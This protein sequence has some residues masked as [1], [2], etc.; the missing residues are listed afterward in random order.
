MNVLT[1]YIVREVLKGSFISLVLLLTLFNLFTFTDELKS[2]G[3]GSYGLQEIFKYLALTSPRVLYELIPSSALLG[4][5]FVLGAMGNNRELIAMRASGISVLGIVRSVMLAG[6]ILAIFAVAVGE[7]FA[8]TAERNARIL[9]MGALN[10]DFIAQSRYGLWLREGSKFINVREIKDDG[11]LSEIYIYDLDDRNFL[12][13]AT[14]ASKALFQQDKQWLLKNIEQSSISTEQVETEQI[15][16]RPW[17]SSIDPKLLSVVVVKP[18]NLSLY[19]LALY[20]DFLKDNKQKSETFELAFWGRVV[21]PFVI[22][23]MLL[24]ATPFVIGVR[25]GVS[26][27]SRMMIGIIIGMS[28]NIID[29]ITGH[30]SLIYHLNPAFMSVL[31]SAVVFSLALYAV[32][33]VR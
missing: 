33:K 11:N 29:K 13:T 10:R 7:F 27:G 14:T 32:R 26:T 12:H 8:P 1:G 16:S 15:E 20:I 5:L 4:S 21:N 9:K 2:L 25:R 19:D 23:V 18:E 28:F 24:V 22:F 30:V 31:P 3:K 6:A 17:K